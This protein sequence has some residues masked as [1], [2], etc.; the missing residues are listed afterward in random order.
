MQCVWI[1]QK[2]APHFLA[3]LREDLLD[4]H[5]VSEPPKVVSDEMLFV[6]RLAAHKYKACHHQRPSRLSTM[7]CQYSYAKSHEDSCLC[8]PVFTSG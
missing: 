7:T 4:V 2:Y 8:M 6:A 3:S 1:V 5:A